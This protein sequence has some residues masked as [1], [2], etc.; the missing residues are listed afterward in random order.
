MDLPLPTLPPPTDHADVPPPAEPPPGFPAGSLMAHI[1]HEP[2]RPRSPTNPFEFPFTLTSTPPNKSSSTH[3]RS[4]LRTAALP[5]FPSVMDSVTRVIGSPRV[6]GLRHDSSSYVRVRKTFTSLLDVDTNICL[7]GDL[8]LLVDIVDIP[9]LPISV[10]IT[11]DAPSLDDCCTCRGYLPLQLSDGTTHWQLCFYCR[12]A[13]ETII[14]PQ[15]ILDSSDVFASWTQTGFK[16][17]RP[18]QIRFDSHDGLLT[19]RLDLDQRDGLYYCPTDVFTV[20]RSPVRGPST[21]RVATPQVPNTTSRPSRYTPTSKSKQVES[22]VWLLRLGSPGVHQLDALPDNVTGIPSVFEYHPFWFIN[23]KVQA[24]IR[25]Q[26]AQRS[27]VRTNERRKCFY[28]D[29]GFMR[30]SAADYS[31]PHKGT[32]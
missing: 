25:K 8:Q 3:G 18:G 7:T 11:G 30:A 22:E 9:P 12:N 26:A 24:R 1:L 17:G 29:F 28:M 10:A 19:M 31:R 6:F 15:A 27:A 21:L 2:S 13:V 14:S 32:D 5:D 23:F 16:D 4:I 20:D